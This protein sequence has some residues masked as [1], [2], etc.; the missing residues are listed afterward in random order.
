MIQDTKAV[1]V[2]N[3]AVGWFYVCLMG[4]IFL[5][6]YLLNYVVPLEQASYTTRI[7]NWSEWSL[8]VGALGVI[9]FKWRSITLKSVVLGAVLGALSGTSHSLHDASLLGILPEGIAVL[10]TFVAGMTLFRALGSTRVPAF[11]GGLAKSLGLGILLAVPLALVNNLYFF[12]QN[13]APQ[14]QSAIYSA[15]EALSPGIHEEVVYRYF[16]LAAC[17]TFL[18]GSSHPRWVWTIAIVMAVV[19]HSLLHLPD[20]F[21]QNPL[22]GLAMLLATSLLFGLPMALLQVRRNLESA[23]AFHWLIDAV[24]FVFGY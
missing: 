18:K 20:L 24:R 10:L 13:G 14:F 3:R 4:L 16:V 6:L 17:L 15:F 19:P 22:M 23:M 1:A 9:L 11:E 7:W 2:S 21:L 12:F 8:A 5:G